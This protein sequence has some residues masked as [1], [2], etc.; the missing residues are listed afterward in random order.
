[1]LNP[2][3]ALVGLQGLV[4]SVP[5]PSPLRRELMGLLGRIHAAR[6]E[7]DRAAEIAEQLLLR[8]EALGDGSD[9]VARQVQLRVKARDAGLRRIAAALEQLTSRVDAEL[10]VRERLRFWYTLGVAREADGDLGAAALAFREA[11]DLADQVGHPSWRVLARSLLNSILLAFDQ[12]QEA[13]PLAEEAVRI[14]REAG[15]AALLIDA[16]TSQGVVFEAIGDTEGFLAA[17]TLAVS[18]ANASGNAAALPVLFGNIAHYHL[19]RNAYAEAEQVSRRALAAAEEQDSRVGRSLALVNLGLALIGQ[20]EV[21]SGRELV[22]ESIALDEAE[23]WLNDVAQTQLELGAALEKAG[24]LA[25]AV[26]AFHAARRLQD[27]IFRE[28]QQRSI[29]AL[30]ADFEARRRQAQIEQLDADNALAVA[31]LHERRLQQWVW[32]LL[33]LMLLG[34]LVLLAQGMRELR[35]SNRSLAGINAQLRLQSERDPLTGLANRRHVQAVL[36]HEGA[37]AGFSG[38]LVLVDVDHFKRINDQ[39]GHA[40]GDAV[41]VEIARRLRA[42]GRESDLAA[43]WGGEEFLLLLGGMPWTALCQ[44]VEQLLANLAHPV[45]NLDTRIP[46]TVSIGFLACPVPGASGDLPFEHAMR[47]VDSALYLAKLRGR[48]RA[49]GIESMQVRDAAT[50]QSIAVDLEHA[51]AL[52]RVR[53]LQITGGGE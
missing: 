17:M 20:G 35:R 23:G 19:G 12:A 7:R 44:R 3:A 11:V 51:E 2:E 33:T 32:A 45:A 37:E 21:A 18:T 53:L 36:R 48:N 34:V 14:A 41:L 40:A 26:E 31:R 43:R 10:S 25:G 39:H 5:E 30:Q 38:C 49:I 22:A 46:V 42:S 24:E 29:T 1:M 50:P 9:L 28:D 16:Y 27:R 52:G 47:L 8:A 4:E 6:G 15:D 13:G